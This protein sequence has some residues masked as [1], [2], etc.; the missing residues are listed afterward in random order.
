MQI[1]LFICSV[2]M[3]LNMRRGE[4]EVSDFNNLGQEEPVPEPASSSNS[5]LFTFN[6][7][8]RYQPFCSLRSKVN[9][10]FIAPHEL[11]NYLKRN[12]TSSRKTEIFIFTF[13]QTNYSF[14]NNPKLAK[15][16]KTRNFWLRFPGF[17]KF[18]RFSF[19]NK[20]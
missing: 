16:S 13:L 7:H 8:S 3:D 9:P 18:C 2:V 4:A 19:E 14:S 11:V 6:D 1:N 20:R 10:G 15:T 12:K 17:H 5:S